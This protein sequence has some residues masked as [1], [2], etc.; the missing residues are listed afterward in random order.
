VEAGVDESD[1]DTE[2]PGVTGAA[3]ATAAGAGSA[4]AGGAAAACRRAGTPVGG[5]IGTVG[6]SKMPYL[7]GNN[8]SSK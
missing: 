8:I 4:G 2:S 7:N 1:P 6:V 5:T 3:W